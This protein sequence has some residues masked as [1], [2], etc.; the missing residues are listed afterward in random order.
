MNY[1]EMLD[2]FRELEQRLKTAENQVQALGFRLTQLEKPDFTPTWPPVAPNQPSPLWPKE[3]WPT[4]YNIKTT[5]KTN[6]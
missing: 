3:F 2:K 4:I 5:D 6:D 1:R